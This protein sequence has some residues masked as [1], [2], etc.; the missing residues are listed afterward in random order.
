MDI[1]H[2]LAWISH[3]QPNSSFPNRHHENQRE[4]ARVKDYYYDLSH[5]ETD[6]LETPF[7]YIPKKDNCSVFEAT[8]EMLSRVPEIVNGIEVF[9]PL[10]NDI[11][12]DPLKREIPSVYRGG[13]TFVIDLDSLRLFPNIVPSFGDQ[14]S[15]RSDM[16]WCILNKCVGGRTIVE[17]PLPVRQERT[18]NVTATNGLDS[19]K[20]RQD[21]Q[22]FAFY[23]ALHDICIKKAKERQKEGYLPWGE[24]FLDL[25]DGEATYFVDHYMKHL[26]ERLLAFEMNSFRV[27]GLAKIIRNQLSSQAWW[28]TDPNLEDE[29]KALD[30][31]LDLFES[32]YDHSRL[33]TFKDEV[34]NVDKTYLYHFIKDLKNMINSYRDS[35]TK[36]P[37]SLLNRMKNF[38]LEHFNVHSLKCLGQGAEGISFTDNKRVYK[39]FHYWKA[40]D[41]E[42]QIAFLGTLVKSWRHMKTLYTIE[43]FQ[44]IDGKAVLVY[45]YEES[46]PYR[47][48]YLDDILTFLRECRKVGVVCTNVHPS[49][50]RVTKSGLKFIDYGSDLRPYSDD[51]FESMC[52]RAYLM[53]KFHNWSNLKLLMRK[54]IHNVH[55]PELYRYQ[56]FRRAV[57]PRSIYNILDPFIIEEVVRI[58][59]KSIFDYGS[60][61][62]R[63]AEKL[64][65][66]GYYVT[67]FDIDKDAILR[68]EEKREKVKFI[69]SDDLEDYLQGDK[70]FDL[71]LCS[72]VLC[73]IEDDDGVRTILNNI[74]SLVNK[75]GKVFLVVCNPFYTLSSSSEFQKRIIPPKA[76]Y[77][78]KFLYEKKL[79]NGSAR[80]DVHRPFHRYRLL[81]EKADLEVIQVK[82]SIGSDVCKLQPNSDFL[83]LELKPKPKKLRNISLLLKPAPWNGSGLSRV[84]GTL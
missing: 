81:C 16:V 52:R 44:V 24:D 36:F 84:S 34:L 78:D 38:L 56:H 47:G 2:N 22:G 75:D 4:R 50:F 60:D 71:V 29:R 39:F 26:N 33:V 32:E 15:R 68:G 70:K 66:H 82:E 73:T 53:F 49:N 65:S 11:I 69:D 58:S 61:D 48:G 17:M 30:R 55:L 5:W 51:Y 7:W 27:R 14:E 54:S 64:A 72:L 3:L 57:D 25:T 23:S 83:L 80:K 76:R 31:F 6:H 18:I 43:D 37:Q 63:I 20:L 13:N 35:S 28:C 79:W 12:Q 1:Y 41:R 74:R 19:E 40:H 46:D 62:G 10:V 59:P 8:K 77:K 21:I 67:C 9:R 42:E 45:P